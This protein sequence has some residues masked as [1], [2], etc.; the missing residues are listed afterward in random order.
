MKINRGLLILVFVAMA[1]LSMAGVAAADANDTAVAVDDQSDDLAQIET[2]DEAISSN[3]TDANEEDALSS[4]DESTLS[5][6]YEG[7]GT[8]EDLQV[9][10]NDGHHRLDRNYRYVEGGP[11]EIVIGHSCTIYGDGHIIDGMGKARIFHVQANS[12]TINGVYFRNG[13]A[14][15]GGAIYCPQR[16]NLVV[17]SC[18]F[19]SCTATAGGAIF[20]GGSGFKLYPNVGE[21]RFWK[22]NATATGAAIYL[23]GA[24]TDATLWGKFQDCYSGEDEKYTSKKGCIHSENP[25]TDA[26]CTFTGTTL[27]VVTLTSS[28]KSIVYGLTDELAATLK[29]SNGTAFAGVNLTVT[30]NGKTE[31][32]TTDKNG[33][34]T[35]KIPVLDVGDYP[36]KI[37]YIDDV[38]YTTQT[39]SVEATVTQA[40]SNVTITPVGDFSFNDFVII[41][42][43]VENRTSVRAELAGESSILTIIGISGN[44]V[45]LGFLPMGKYSLTIFNNVTANINGASA[46]AN[47][48]VGKSATQ[49]ESADVNATYGSSNSIAVTLKDAKGNP[50]AGKNVTI[51]FNGETYK[52]ETDSKGQITLAIPQ[53]LA[54][55]AYAA[56]ISFAGDDY[57]VKS[58]KNVTVNITRDTPV[59]SADDVT[60]TYNANR[61]IV[62]TLKDSRG[63]ALSGYSI[64]VDLNGA[65]VYVTDNSGQVKIPVGTLIPKTYVAKISFSGNDNYTEAAKDVKV[66]V[67]KIKSKITAKK[68]TYKAKSKKKKFKITLKDENGKAIKNVKVRLIVQKIKKTS[69][70]TSKSKNN[71]KNIKKTNSKGKITFKINRYKKGK[72]WATVKFYGNDYYEKTTKKV[73]ITLK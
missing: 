17:E 45:D 18:V 31:N 43:T 42:F 69:K 70:K 73:K 24:V 46:S 14:G 10:L 50:L 36:A 3:S 26:G 62:I 59:L 9:Y 40:S 44:T 8:F 33:T 32:Y 52:N 64:T 13:N 67:N 21:I 27:K 6:D 37:E 66:T 61:D 54:P 7:W 16:E 58:S 28:S 41:E 20:V 1:L 71:K 65:R 38:V 22:C 12:V 48:T 29:Y 55:D 19:E 23:T 53:A 72:Y 2:Q 49:I 15:Y 57:Y 56:K 35:I 68:K 63:A 51:E 4:A 34:V 5:G 39:V 60:A 25:Y 47:L 30:F 11:E